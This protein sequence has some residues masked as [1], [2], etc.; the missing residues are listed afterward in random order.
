M[1]LHVISL[2]LISIIFLA[3]KKEK[4]IQLIEFIPILGYIKKT[5][6]IE[7]RLNN[8]HSHYRDFHEN[9]NMRIWIGAF[10]NVSDQNE[11]NIED[12]E[13]LFI[14]TYGNNFLTENEKKV[15]ANIKKSIC[16]IN[17]FYKT[18]E[19]PWLRKPA[20]ISFM[21]D[22]LIHET[23]DKIKRTL[24]AKLKSIKW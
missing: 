13:T 9:E 23:E 24:V 4:D 7:Q 1:N 8:W 22:V 6:G 14:S 2:Y 10:G 20:D 15:K 17:L 11:E 19:E 5:D 21:D 12:A 18:S 16:I 3:I